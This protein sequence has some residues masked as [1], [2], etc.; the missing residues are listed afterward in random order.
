MAANGQSSKRPAYVPALFGAFS[1][2][3]ARVEQACHDIGRSDSQVT[4]EDPLAEDVHQFAGSWNY[5]LAGRRA[6][7]RRPVSRSR[8]RSVPG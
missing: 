4:G 1:G 3:G 7:G 8:V 6:D 5:G 2:F